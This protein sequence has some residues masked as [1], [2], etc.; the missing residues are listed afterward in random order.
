MKADLNKWWLLPFGILIASALV[1]LSIIVFEPTLTNRAFAEVAQQESSE[2]LEKSDAA[3]TPSRPTE[4]SEAVVSG[5]PKT[6]GAADV[7]CSGTKATDYVCYQQRYQDLVHNFGVRAA[8]A[9]LRNEIM[10][11]DFVKANCHQMTHVIGRAAV[12]LYGDLP[13]TYNHGDTFC[14]SGYYHGATE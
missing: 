14:G 5:P 8:F 6:S 10:K 3:D 13:R 1:A 9:E 7:D 2:P 11:D 4:T 12:D